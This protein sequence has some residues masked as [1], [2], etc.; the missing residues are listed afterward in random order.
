MNTL[1]THDG[2]E[3]GLN[4]LGQQTVDGKPIVESANGFAFVDGVIA[5]IIAQLEAKGLTEEQKDAI[6]D[7]YLDS[8]AIQMTTK[9]GVVQPE[10]YLG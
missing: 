2:Y 5:D 10:S 8:L 9:N 1:N 6:A 4:D 7:D 3:N